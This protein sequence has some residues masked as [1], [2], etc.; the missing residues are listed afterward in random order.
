MPDASLLTS[1][2]N[3]SAIVAAGLSS[4]GLPKHNIS[5]SVTSS[6]KQ[7]GRS[8]PP[9]NAYL[10]ESSL[11]APEKYYPLKVFVCKQLC[12]ALERIL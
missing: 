11:Q 8:A 6:L 2:R 12:K 5:G 3:S 1:I 7:V 10:T 4:G 9:S